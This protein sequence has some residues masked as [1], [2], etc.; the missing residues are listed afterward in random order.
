V[1]SS[2]CNASHVHPSSRQAVRSA[3]RQLCGQ[4]QAVEAGEEAH[5]EVA[6]AVLKAA[7]AASCRVW[8][9]RAIF[10]MMGEQPPA[11]GLYGH[12]K[13]SRRGGPLGATPQLP[14]IPCMEDS[15]NEDVWKLLLA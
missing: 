5:S 14:F 9:Q 13:G 7:A 10:A 8:L 1:V 3:H 2:V 6:A 15:L 11:V 12:A 4:A